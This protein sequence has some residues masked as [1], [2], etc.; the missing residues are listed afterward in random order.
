MAV[1]IGFLGRLGWDSWQ[2]GADERQ[3]IQTLTKKTWVYDNEEWGKTTFTFQGNRLTIEERSKA[4]GLKKPFTVSYTIKGDFLVFDEKGS[5]QILTN[6]PY[7]ID[8]L[9]YSADDLS[10]LRVRFI[11]ADNSSLALVWYA[12]DSLG[13]SVETDHREQI[14]TS[15]KED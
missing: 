5:Q 1:M 7:L 3:L 10:H 11:D 15:E 4:F 12:D 6:A 8:N 2:R 14:L 13:D 9:F